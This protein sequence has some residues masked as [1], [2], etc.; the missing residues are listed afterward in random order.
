[1]RENTG[2]GLEKR[3]RPG[4]RVWT[5]MLKTRGIFNME[6]TRSTFAITK[7][8]LIKCGQQMRDG[9]KS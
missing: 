1:M 2:S 7:I 5:F 6:C 9:L 8:T 4:I 3:C